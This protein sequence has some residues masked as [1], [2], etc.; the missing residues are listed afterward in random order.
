MI[1]QMN[2]IGSRAAT[3]TTKSQVSRSSTA[4]RIS[5]TN[6]LPGSSYTP[7][8]RGRNRRL[9]ARRIAPCNGGSVMIII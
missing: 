2:A 3:S 1:S 6:L 5:A 7:T 8:A 4:S 9:N